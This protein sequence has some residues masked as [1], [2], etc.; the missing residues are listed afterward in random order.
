MKLKELVRKFV[1]EIDGME[2]EDCTIEYLL[3]LEDFF[4]RI[5]SDKWDE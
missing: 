1:K 3:A 2:L 5:R 4:K